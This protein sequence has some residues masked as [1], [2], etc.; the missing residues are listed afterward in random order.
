MSVSIFS[1]ARRICEKSEWSVTHL[2]IQKM[3]F[4]AHMFYMGDKGKQLVDGHYEA[5]SLGP[6]NPELYQMLKKYGSNHV[7]PETLDF[8]SIIPDVHP[9][10]VY[11]DAVLRIPQHKLVGITHWKEGAWRKNYKPHVLGIRISNED[12]MEEVEKRRILKAKE[13]EKE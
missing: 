11:L 12:I 7:M 9:G 8:A 6:V 13:N 10:A 1:A 2:H 5:W 3:T 4:I